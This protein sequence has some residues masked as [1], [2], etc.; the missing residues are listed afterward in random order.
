[1]NGMT[2]YYKPSSYEPTLENI[3]IHKAIIDKIRLI[4]PKSVLEIGSGVGLMGEMIKRLDPAIKY[5]GVEPDD[6]QIGL[7]KARCPELTFVS[8]SLYDDPEQLGLGKFDLVISTDVIEHLFLPRSLVT[9]AKANLLPGGNVL[10]CTPEFGSY[11]KNILY[12]IFNKWDKVHSPLWDGGHIKFFSRGSMQQ[13]F[14]EEGFV[15]FQWATVR[16]VNIPILPMSMIC[17]CQHAVL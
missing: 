8:G 2:H 16:N 15:D 1:M 3:K 5:V 14:E 12:S 9:F 13:I 11:W 17:I 4:K 7:A 10:T 6:V